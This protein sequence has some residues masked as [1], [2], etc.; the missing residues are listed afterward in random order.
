[1]ICIRKIDT[2]MIYCEVF[3][4]TSTLTVF[5]SQKFIF[6]QTPST[7]IF[8]FYHV[9]FKK[10]S[11]LWIPYFNF[12]FSQKNKKA[13]PARQ[14]NFFI[15]TAGLTGRLSTCLDLLFITPTIFG[16]RFFSKSLMP[17]TT[18]WRLREWNW[19]SIRQNSWPPFLYT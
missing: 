15:Y 13:P 11:R 10:T 1:M 8:L 18:F 3:R 16:S 6:F 17:Y 12:S 14:Y 4:K 9:I 5:R 7:F 19:I 2:S